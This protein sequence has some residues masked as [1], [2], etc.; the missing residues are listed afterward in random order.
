MSDYGLTSFTETGELTQVRN[1]LTAVGRGETCVGIRARN[2]IVIAAE[3]KLPTVL[4][5]ETSVH[6]I[7]NLCEYMGV[8]YSGIGPDFQAVLLKMRKDIQV[9]HSRYR[10]RISPFML[11]KQVG[12]LVQEY[13]QAGGVRPFGIGMIVGGYDEELGPQIF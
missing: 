5:D 4:M 13:S 11:C 6:K 2:G 1:A 8:G 12:D 3:K 7:D 9:Y 10:D